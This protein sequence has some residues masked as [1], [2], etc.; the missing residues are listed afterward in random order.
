MSSELT[1]D[2]VLKVNEIFHDEE[3]DKYAGEHPEIFELE[4]RRWR[5]LAERFFK[6]S[7]TLKILDVGTGTGFVPMQICPMLKT[8]D[9]VICS[10][11]SEKMLERSK[12]ELADKNFRNNFEYLKLE[13]ESLF[14]TEQSL[15]A[16]IMNSVL[17]HL[18]NTEKSLKE[19][20]KVLKIGGLLVIA[21]EPHSDF[22]RH[23]FLWFNYRLWRVLASPRLLLE[24]IMKRLGQKNL[25]DKYIQDKSR[26]SPELAETN[27]R[28]LAS[29]LITEPLSPWKMG[30]IVDYYSA[31][32]FNLAQIR[33]ILPNYQ[34]EFFATYN[35]LYRVFMYSR[36]NAILKA[37]NLLLAKI[38]PKFG[39]T[40]SVVLRKIS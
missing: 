25:F 15:D 9:T 3:A 39:A 30:K 14:L 37:V 32:G 5:F 16:V 35:H 2:F 28:L 24:A 19:M 27:R 33:Q 17:H 13:D 26:Y 38:F 21:H 40:F 6:T 4:R 23:K 22:F 8:G 7:E 1:A 12:K 18:P 36:G 29:G 10:D 11:I 20:D 31:L 34:T